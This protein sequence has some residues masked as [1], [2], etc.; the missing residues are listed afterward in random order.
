MGEA[1][2]PHIWDRF[3]MVAV[4]SYTGYQDRQPALWAELERVGLKGRVEWF[5][6]F[7]SPF[8]ERFANSVRVSGEIRDV[9]VFNCAMGHYRI[10]KT[11]YLLGKSHLLVL[12]DDVRF[13][14]DAALLERTVRTL[15]DDYDVAKLEWFFR[16]G[17]P[18]PAPDSPWMDPRGK[19]STW[20]GCATAYSARGME[21][22]SRSME[23]AA[24]YNDL[25]SLMWPSDAYETE[26]NMRGMK[27]YVSYPC[28]ATQSARAMRSGLH[29][30]SWSA[31]YGRQSPEGGASA[32]VE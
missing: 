6:N 7:P 19:F 1:V 4:L 27:L 3:D 32:F 8:T 9:N 12:E 16:T 14:K 24:R 5:W 30:G 22:K 11:A 15:P 29:G 13:V 23:S 31:R 25:H 21:W 18:V 17:G 2:D 26:R 20:G 10:V 28:V